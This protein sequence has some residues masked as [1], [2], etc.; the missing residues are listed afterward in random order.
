MR[1]TTEILLNGKTATGFAV[2][3]AV[4]EELGGGRRP[5]V[6]VTINGYAYR[7]TVAAMGGRFMVPLS[8]ERRGEI[9]ES[10]ASARRPET[11]ERRLTAALTRL[12]A[13]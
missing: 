5:Q 6:T 2:P 9:V 12:R 7:T 13:R 4:V 1:F 11:R 3:D 10:L 8:A